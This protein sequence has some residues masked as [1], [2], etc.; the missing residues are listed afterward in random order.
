MGKLFSSL[1][2]SSLEY[3]SAVSSLHSLAETVFLLALTLFRL[4]SSEHSLHLLKLPYWKRFS[5]AWH[6]CLRNKLRL[7]HTM[8]YI[9]YYNWVDLSR[10]IMLFSSKL[11][12]NLLLVNPIVI[13]Q[14]YFL[15]E[16]AFL[17]FS[18]IFSGVSP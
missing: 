8:T 13:F 4:I 5:H 17:A 12:I 7:L 2:T 1:C 16:T 15:S 18:T 3:V 10:G 6:F 11:H 9:L 14:N